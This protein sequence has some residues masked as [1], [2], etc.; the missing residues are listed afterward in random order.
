MIYESLEDRFDPMKSDQ[1]LSGK[2][3]VPGPGPGPAEA[4]QNE[5]QDAAG[6]T[7]FR[8]PYGSTG[9]VERHHSD[10]QHDGWTDCSESEAEDGPRSSTGSRWRN[11]YGYQGSESSRHR[12]SRS[13]LESISA[14]S[15]MC[16][17]SQLPDKQGSK[18]THQSQMSLLYQS[19]QQLADVP[20][21][22]QE[23]LTAT[24][25]GQHRDRFTMYKVV[26]QF[27][28]RVWFVLRRYS[29]FAL[30]NK[31]LQKQFPVFHFELPSRKIDRSKFN[32]AFIDERQHALNGYLKNLLI[33]QEFAQCTHVKLFL[34]LDDPPKIQADPEAVKMFCQELQQQNDFL[35]HQLQAARVE[36]IALR[37]GKIPSG[38]VEFKPV[39]LS[40]NKGFEEQLK[41]YQDALGSA[42]EEEQKAKRE[43]EDLRR[44]MK[45]ESIGAK[46]ASHQ[47]LMRKDDT[48][49]KQME[50]F[51]KLRV[52]LDEKLDDMCKEVPGG[53]Q[54]GNDTVA[55]KKFIR[56]WETTLQNNHQETVEAFTEE[57]A[58]LK[59]HLTK[60]SE[61][62]KAK[63]GEIRQQRD[64]SHQNKLW[65]SY[66]SKQKR[67]KIKTLG[68]QL[69]SAE[70]RFFYAEEQYFLAL[71]VGAKLSISMSHHKKFSLNNIHPQ[72]MF[73]KV[74]NEGIA[75]K[76]W[77]NWIARE[78]KL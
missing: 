47:I 52:N 37:G 32:H 26:I 72:E 14:A 71:F 23:E 35:H 46:E 56:D 15:S 19:N 48:I 29:D 2:S 30:L 63:D 31:K 8:P 41:D 43:L 40:Q 39:P 18:W 61:V 7:H 58:E 76:H 12:A 65:F 68:E 54:E 75:I 73:E 51:D 17:V 53:G 50:N 11:G 42:K 60:K 1:E 34:K 36:I 77:A 66:D 67:E 9:V 16:N 22:F 4:I 10:Y 64:E 20:E 25:V 21:E 28:S 45:A 78:M 44:E 62:I 70:K 6:P 3:S 33:H 55:L 38:P 49:K 13:N 5:N 27:E 59:F 24:I 69:K 57:I 74:R